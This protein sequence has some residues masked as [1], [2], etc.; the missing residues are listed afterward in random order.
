[1]LT[2]TVEPKLFDLQL[3]GSLIANE[4]V[5]NNDYSGTVYNK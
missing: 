1:M 3:T 4:M 2:H 5:W